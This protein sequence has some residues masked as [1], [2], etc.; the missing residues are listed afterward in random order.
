M[1][2]T[3]EHIQLSNNMENVKKGES[4]FHV[5]VKQGHKGFFCNLWK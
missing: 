5:Q 1:K 2:Y 3:I 4:E